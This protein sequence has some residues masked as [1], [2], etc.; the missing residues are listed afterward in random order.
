MANALYPLWKQELI[1]ATANTPLTGTIKVVLV[2]TGVYTYSALHQYYSSVTG[3]PTSIAAAP[4]TLASK[5][6]VNGVFDAGDITFTAVTLGTNCEALI[7][8]CDTGVAATSPLIA[9][10][11]TGITGMPVTPNGGDINV[12]WSASGIFAL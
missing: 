7:I 3:V 6:Y 8:Y 5:T 1:K 12:V 10:L 9:Y 2:D 4:A 11:D